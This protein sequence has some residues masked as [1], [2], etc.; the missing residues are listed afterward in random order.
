MERKAP[1][2]LTTIVDG[3]CVTGEITE[4]SKYSIHV[5]TLTPYSGWEDHQLIMSWSGLKNYKDFRSKKGEDLA[6][7]TLKTCYQKAQ[8]V[9]SN[10]ERLVKVYDQHAKELLEVNKIDDPEIRQRIRYKLEEWFFNS[11]VFWRLS[12]GLYA[13]SYDRKKIYE[14]LDGYL[15]KRDKV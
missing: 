4:W 6:R 9:N 3:I 8:M 14:I 7:I 11:A 15:M 1:Y 13:N 5:I 10:V 12:T 2:L